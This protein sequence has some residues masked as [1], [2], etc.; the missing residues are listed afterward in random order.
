MS[1]HGTDNTSA[2][3]GAA[4]RPDGWFIGLIAGI[5]AAFLVKWLGNGTAVTAILMGVLVFLVYGVLLGMFWQAP[6]ASGLGAD[7]GGHHGDHGQNDHGHGDHAADDHGHD[8]HGH[9][10]PTAMVETAHAPV[11]TPVMAASGGPAKPLGLP[12]PRGGQADALQEIEGIGPVLEKLC[13]DLGIYHFDQIAGWGAGEIAWMDSNLK[14]FKGRVS[15]DRWVAQA[16]I[17]GT[18]GLDA[19]R[20][21]AKTNDY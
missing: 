21:R 20:I 5:I 11:A 15:R 14:G 6:P 16:R 10:A 1:G 12:G 13:H 8:D 9:P 3:D 2:T 19:F 18:E 17:I 4:V 7:A